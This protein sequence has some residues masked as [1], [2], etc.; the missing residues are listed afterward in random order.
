ML[1]NTASLHITV[2]ASSSMKG[3]KWNQTMTA[4][5]AICKAASM[6]NNIHVTVSFRTT[7]SDHVQ[8][9]PYVVLAYDSN[10]DKFSKVK[11]LFPFLS[12]YGCTPEGLAIEAIMNSF[13]SISTDVSDRYFLNLSDGEPFFVIRHATATSK[14]YSGN[15]AVAHTKSQIKKVRQRG[16]E[17]LSYFISDNDMSLSNKL[18]TDFAEMYGSS[19]EFINVNSVVELS[20]TMNKKFLSKPI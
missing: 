12:P 1:F 17:V 11:Q 15:V 3:P 14:A 7:F 5:V 10:V 2:D 6:A 13:V 8:D 18:K 19:A 4:V 9:L 16:M 20:R